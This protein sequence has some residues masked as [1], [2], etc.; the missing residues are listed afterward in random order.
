MSQKAVLFISYDGMTDPLGQSQVLPYLS[1]LSRRGYQITLL[2][3]EKKERFTKNKSIIEEIVTANNIDWHPIPFTTSPP[4]LAKYYDL[5]QLGKKAESLYRKKKFRLVHCRSYVSAAIGLKLKKKFGVKLLFDMRGFWVDERV[6]G[7]AWNLQNP[8]YRYA[9]KSYK[10]KEAAYIA[11]SDAIIS[12]TEAGKRE[13]E[14]WPSYK[15]AP[16]QVIPCSA[17]FDL[18]KQITP[19][20]QAQSRALLG[21]KPEALVI[22]YLGSVGMWYLLDEML[23]LFTYIKKKYPEALF[24]FITP[25]PAAAILEPA[26]KF[27]LLPGDFI[28]RSAS[29]KEVPVFTAASDINLFFIKQSY[30]KIASSPTKLGEILAMGLPV[31]C[32]SGVGDVA[33]IVRDTQSGIAIDDFSPSSFEKVILLIPELLDKEA[34]AIRNRAIDYYTLDN[35][36]KKYAEVYR[37]LVSEKEKVV[38]TSDFS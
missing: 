12:L 5:Y 7:G 34:A 30:S 15:K 10:R 18:F 4:V 14:T 25:E 20:Q 35:A 31:I 13:M 23:E 22:S 17:D 11:N 1:G 6:D 2:S 3:C 29:R 37:Y 38:N 19:V 33:E 26:Q 24:L 32:N 27:N 36:I 28:I 21:I 9:Y 8:L 16:I